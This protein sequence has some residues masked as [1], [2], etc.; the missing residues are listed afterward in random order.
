[1]KGKRQETILKII[2][3]NAILTQ[4]DLQNALKSVGFNVTQSTVSRDIKE[5]CLVKG[6]DENGRY[7]YI[8]NS[9]QTS[10]KQMFSH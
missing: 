3:D 10:D 7:R 2:K 4:D 5:L 6:H 1:M 9:N 8:V